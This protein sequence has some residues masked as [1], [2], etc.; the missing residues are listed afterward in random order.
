MGSLSRRKGLCTEREIVHLHRRIGIDAERVP[1]SGAAAYQD[2]AE[3][4]DLYPWGK[5]AAPLCC[6]VKRY[7]GTRGTKGM[8]DA[9]GNADALFIRYDAERGQPAEPPIVVVPFRTWERLLK[10]R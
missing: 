8:L 3:D 1:L 5:D 9:L 6:Q 2:N 10:R 7:K 4:V